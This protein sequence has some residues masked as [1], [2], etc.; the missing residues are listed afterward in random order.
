MYQDA[1]MVPARESTLARA[2][3]PGE[4]DTTR[5]EPET[6]SGLGRNMLK[7]CGRK[8]VYP[9][10]VLHLSTECGNKNHSA[11]FPAAL[12]E[13]FIRLFT[14]EGDTVLDPFMGSGTTVFAARHAGRNAIGIEIMP[15]YFERV[16]K[17]IGRQPELFQL[18]GL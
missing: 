6:G 10:N 9:A 1:V 8:M 12:P 2:E 13:W 11:A 18:P 17:E 4:N 5:F 7:T 15:E 14:R 3:R 16:K